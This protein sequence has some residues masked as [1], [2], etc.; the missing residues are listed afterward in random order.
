MSNI[1]CTSCVIRPQSGPRSSNKVVILG[2]TGSSSPAVDSA[3]YTAQRH[4]LVD[5]SCTLESICIIFPGT[6]TDRI[7]KRHQ[8]LP[9]LLKQTSP[10]L[11]AMLRTFI[12]LIPMSLIVNKGSD[13]N[14]LRFKII[15]CFGVEPS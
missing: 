15:F 7:L 10:S 2:I 5:I 12:E 1:L 6:L 11:S 9:K 4:A 13:F 3:G 8:R 14:Q